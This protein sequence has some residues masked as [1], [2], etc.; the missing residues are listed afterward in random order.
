MASLI[1]NVH[2]TYYDHQQKTTRSG[3]RR[4]PTPSSCKPGYRICSSNL[5]QT[6]PSPGSACWTMSGG[7]IIPAGEIGLSTSG[8]CSRWT[9][10]LAGPRTASPLLYFPA[11]SSRSNQDLTKQY[12]R[13][14]RWW[15]FSKPYRYLLYHRVSWYQVTIHHASKEYHLNS[16]W[17]TIN[18]S[19]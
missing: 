9:R 5:E 1:D 15:V 18:K 11:S 6:K 13:S 3:S 8:S 7:R 12:P 14:P 4:P 16:H 17:N 2:S 10:R 19:S